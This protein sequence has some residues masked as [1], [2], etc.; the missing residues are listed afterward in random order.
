MFELEY[1]G[2]NSVVLTTKNKRIFID[3]NVELIGLKSLKLKDDVQLAT[4]KRFLVA[5]EENGLQLE[6]PGEYETGPF[7]IQGVAAQRHIDQESDSKQ[8][9]IYRIGIQDVRIAVLGNIAPK[10]TEAQLETIG[11]VD[12]LVLPV[13]GNGYTLDASHAVALVHQIEPRI[14]IPVHYAESGVTYEVPQNN[15]D[16]FVSELRAPVETMSKLKVKSSA[17]IPQALT[18]Y[19]LERS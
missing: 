7:S 2:G 3:P 6:G 1:K 19:H 17:S 14:V 18:V 12:I 9:T 8:T 10:L 15:L 5:P 13:G 16:S 4:E 11:M